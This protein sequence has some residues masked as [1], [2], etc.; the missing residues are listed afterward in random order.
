MVFAKAVAQG[1]ISRLATAAYAIRIAN[2]LSE[3]QPSPS[4]STTAYV[5]SS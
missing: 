2:A 5:W 3:H 1:E 4:A